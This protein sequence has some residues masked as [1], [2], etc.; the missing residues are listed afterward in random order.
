FGITLSGAQP[1]D[2]SVGGIALPATVSPG[3]STSFTIT[4]DP[5]AG[6]TRT[7]TINIANNECGK[8]PYDFAVQGTGLTTAPPAITSC[9]ANQS[10]NAAAGQCTASVSFNVTASGTPAPTITCM[11]GTTTITSPYNFPVGTSNVI[12][13]AT[14]GVAPDATC[15]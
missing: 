3:G 8:D 2:F 14:N 6:G 11:I 4:F 7:A 1:S 10:V 12:C 5:S 13:T 9:L 15:S